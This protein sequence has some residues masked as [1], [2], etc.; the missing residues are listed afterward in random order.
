MSNQKGSKTIFLFAKILIITIFGCTWLIMVVLQPGNPDTRLRV[1]KHV[2]CNCIFDAAGKMLFAGDKASGTF[3]SEYDYLGS[4]EIPVKAS[5]DVSYINEDTVT[6]RLTDD[7]TGILLTASDYRSGSFKNSD[8]YP[9]GFPP[10]ENS[11]GKKFKFEIISNKGN[12]RNAIFF[13][14]KK[15]DIITYYQIPASVLLRPDTFARYFLTKLY[16]GLHLR[17]NAAYSGLYLFPVIYAIYYASV[18]ATVRMRFRLLSHLMMLLISY[19]LFI[20]KNQ[21]EILF[22]FGVIIWLILI[23]THESIYKN[24]IVIPLVWSLIIFIASLEA[25]RVITEKMAVWFLVFVSG[26][27]ISRNWKPVVIK[28]KIV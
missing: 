21:I 1:Y 7:T 17:E 25:G 4:I 15:G 6:F 2:Q 9:F 3:I 18:E 23:R 27:I 14:D 5:L 8:T 16:L 20:I 26:A 28:T 11:K 13:P 24:R 10:I 22:Y 19:D 12:S